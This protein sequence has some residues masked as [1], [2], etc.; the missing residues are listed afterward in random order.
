[1]IVADAESD[2][3][4]PMWW[5]HL[6]WQAAQSFASSTAANE[7]GK[8]FLASM[9]AQLNLIHR[10]KI[11]F[12]FRFLLK[13][14][15]PFRYQ[16]TKNHHL[17]RLHQYRRSLAVLPKRA[18]QSYKFEIQFVIDRQRAVR[19]QLLQRWQSDDHMPLWI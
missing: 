12:L 19:R 2:H 4:V 8:A 1:M 11:Q 10:I 7:L 17:Q 18:N 16:H 14:P 3:A 9:F 13:I 5:G 6:Q 15:D